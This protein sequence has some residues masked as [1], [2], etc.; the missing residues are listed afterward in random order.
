MLLTLVIIWAIY[1]ALRG[2]VLKILLHTFSV[3][4]SASYYSLL[5]ISDHVPTTKQIAPG[6]VRDPTETP[7]FKGLGVFVLPP[8]RSAISVSTPGETN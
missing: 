6:F 7:P 2:N 8:P 4:S 3:H 1:S 5:L